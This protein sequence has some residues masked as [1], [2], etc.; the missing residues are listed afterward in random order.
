MGY[1]QLLQTPPCSTMGGTA[2]ESPSVSSLL[3]TMNKCACVCA[4]ACMHEGSFVPVL[5]SS[6]KK[7]NK[8]TKNPAKNREGEYMS[9]QNHTSS[10]IPSL[11]SEEVITSREVRCSY[12]WFSG[13]PQYS[14]NEG[15]NVTSFTTFHPY[16]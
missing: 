5:L 16:A 2:I 12:I 1:K 14:K 10:P 11:D 13:R 15:E 9:N 4:R 3:L 8:N 6:T 7:K